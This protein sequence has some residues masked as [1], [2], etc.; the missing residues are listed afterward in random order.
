MRLVLFGAS[1]RVGR[2]LIHHALGLGHEVV[3]IVRESAAFEDL[4]GI[5][6]A[7]VSS[8]NADRVTLL[9]DGADAVLSA[10]SAQPP[11]GLTRLTSAI[12][13]GLERGGVERIVT[14]GHAGLCVRDTGVHAI[15]SAAGNND[16]EPEAVATRERLRDHVGALRVLESSTRR[17]TVVCPP[18]I[19]EGPATGRY[20]ESVDGMPEG[21]KTISLGD[22]AHAA[23]KALSRDELVHQRLGIAT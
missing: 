13:D 15:A 23:I 4:P 17:W 19:V 10:L 2:S 22:V 16:E 1:G 7:R 14:I 5:E 20:R 6:I 11:D 9:A 18:T 21:G 3:A 12:V 8:I